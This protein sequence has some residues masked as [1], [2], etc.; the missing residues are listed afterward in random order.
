MTTERKLQIQF[1]KELRK[2]FAA[3]AQL[4]P[5]APETVAQYVQAD[6]RIVLRINTR[7]GHSYW[8]TDRR[9][10]FGAESE[11]ESGRQTQRTERSLPP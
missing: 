5:P 6:E 1:T 2:G 3:N 4:H 7:T 9:V 8:F 10:L 11:V